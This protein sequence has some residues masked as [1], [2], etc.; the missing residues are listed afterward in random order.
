M[1]GWSTVRLNIQMVWLSMLAIFIQ[2]LRRQAGIYLKSLIVIPRETAM[3]PKPYKWL[4]VMRGE[5]SKSSFKRKYRGLYGS[6]RES[7]K[8]LI[9]ELNPLW[10]WEV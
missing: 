6:P 4:A 3:K 1:F 5:I 7:W 2:L 9:R 10:F 8:R